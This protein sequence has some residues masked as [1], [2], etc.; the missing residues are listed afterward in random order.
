MEYEYRM[1]NIETNQPAQ[2]QACNLNEEL[3]QVEFVFSDKTGTLTCN[4]MLFR[5]FS[6]PDR[7]FGS[8]NLED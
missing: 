3:G 5:R 8:A 1:F 2:V 6:I 7:V 4:Q